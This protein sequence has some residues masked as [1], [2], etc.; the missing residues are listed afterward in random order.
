MKRASG[1]A[2]LAIGA[3]KGR[4]LCGRRKAGFWPLWWSQVVPGASLALRRESSENVSVSALAVQPPEVFAIVFRHI[5]CAANQGGSLQP[6]LRSYLPLDLP[7]EF[8]SHHTEPLDW[9]PEPLLMMPARMVLRQRKTV[10]QRRRQTIG[11]VRGQFQK[12]IHSTLEHAS[13]STQQR[14]NPQIQKTRTFSIIR[15][16]ETTPY[17]SISTARAQERRQK[18]R[19]CFKTVVGNALLH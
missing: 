1:I 4:H 13:T 19:G 2:L 17:A 9:R 10:A 11:F 5:H 14:L 3:L 16:G 18:A 15:C 6:D 7:P 8:R 12:R